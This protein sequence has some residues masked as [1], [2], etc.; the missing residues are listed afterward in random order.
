MLWGIY[1]MQNICIRMWVGFGVGVYC[2]R[3]CRVVG[4]VG[5]SGC[6]MPSR[7]VGCDWG[8]SWGCWVEDVSGRGWQ[9]RGG[10]SVGGRG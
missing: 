7:D 1:E 3:G 8:A 6:G 9:D 10:V 2:W 4:G 5:N